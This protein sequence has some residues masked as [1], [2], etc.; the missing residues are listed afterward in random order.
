MRRPLCQVLRRHRNMSQTKRRP[1][2]TV[3]KRGFWIEL[4]TVLRFLG[5]VF[6]RVGRVFLIGRPQP[7]SE[8]ECRREFLP[9]QHVH[10]SFQV[11]GDGR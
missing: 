1:A 8:T 7:V 5:T 3:T 9:A 11:V 10:H 4:L 2:Q 6:L